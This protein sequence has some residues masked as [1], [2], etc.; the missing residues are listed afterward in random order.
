MTKFEYEIKTRKEFGFILIII[1]VAIML[2]K[3]VFDAL[4][5]P[6]ALICLVIGLILIFDLDEKLDK[7]IR[8]VN[9]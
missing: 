4:L 7:A 8:K 5:I 2:I 1:A 9:K 3:W 6:I